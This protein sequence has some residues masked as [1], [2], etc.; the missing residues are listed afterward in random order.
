M[1]YEYDFRKSAAEGEYKSDAEEFYDY[2][3]E[4]W[5]TV[6][7]DPKTGKGTVRWGRLGYLDFYSSGNDSA[8]VVDFQKPLYL[9]ARPEDM[10]KALEA[11]SKILDD[12]G[13]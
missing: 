9:K 5:N 1:S 7:F 10:I 12:T 4:N 8:V 11:I 13:L 2:A 6:K 3:K